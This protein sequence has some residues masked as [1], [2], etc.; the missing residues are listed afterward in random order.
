[1]KCGA[2]ALASVLAGLVCVSAL[3]APRNVEQAKASATEA[4]DEVV[5]AYLNSQWTELKEAQR[6]V[7]RFTTYLTAGQRADLLYIRK[8]APEFRP[9]WWRTCK[10][11]VSR[12]IRAKVWGRNLVAKYTP[13]DKP[14]MSGKINAMG[15]METTVFWNPSLVD[16]T[17]SEKGR[18]AARHGLTTGNI[19]EFVV[20]R[21]LG[22]SYIT[23]SL[24]VKTVMGLYND[25]KHLYQHLQWFYGNV[26]SL[27]H[28]SPKAR[29]AAMLVH[30][31]TLQDASAAEAYLR[32]CRAVSSLFTAIVLAEPS[33]WPSVQLPHSIPDQAAEAT[34]GLALYR[35]LQPTWTLAEDRAFREAL[36]KFFRA[37]GERV[38]KSRGRLVLPNR[39]G[40][41]L[42]EPDDRK[43]QANRDQWVKQQ[44]EKASK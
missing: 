18:T 38:L 21:Q 6:A 1:M 41:M 25:N 35:S 28:C 44:L 16:S 32:S 29:R 26:T 22:L 43:F 20:W 5:H 7:S 14:D 27:Y 33:Q 30:A 10:S 42:M 39:M 8:V 15:R 24:P 31:T 13:A 3:A 23:S 19:G 34:T 9:P 12:R 17:A 4:Y 40:F 37:N 2:L 36:R 11:T